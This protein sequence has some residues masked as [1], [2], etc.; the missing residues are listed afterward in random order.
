V[1]RIELVP[2][3]QYGEQTHSLFK[4]W[5]FGAA[6]AK[7]LPYRLSD[8]EED[9]KMKLVKMCALIVS[10]VLAA[11]ATTTTTSKTA[12]V[13]TDR[14]EI[15]E[16]DWYLAQIRRGNTTLDINRPKLEAEGNGDIY[17]LRFDREDRVS[18][19]G[20]P[21]RYNAP[22]KWGDGSDLSF[23]AVASTM[24]FPVK[25][26]EVLKEHDYFAY[27]RLVSSWAL[28]GGGQ[29]ELFCEDQSGQAVLI[30]GKR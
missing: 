3:S 16:I 28:T 7:I 27:L 1:K 9:F 4:I 23:G 15:A 5:N 12:T 29:L 22:C 10:M 6:N 13:T 8:T 21:N 17:S 18:G 24:M 19:K 11:C 25:E 14:N 2:K 30:Y 20:A 26:P